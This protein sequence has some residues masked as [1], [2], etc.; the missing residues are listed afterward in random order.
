MNPDTPSSTPPAWRT[1]PGYISEGYVNFESIHILL[2][3]F[4]RDHTSPS[5]LP[6]KDLFGPADDF[7]W[8]RHPM[9]E[10]IIRSPANLDVLTANPA[11]PR[12]SI[13]IIEPWEHV[14]VNNL[15]EPVRASKN[16]AY[17]AQK[18]ADAD[19]LL[20][21]I[22][23][24]GVPDLDRLIPLIT[25][26]LAVVVE[27]GD[28]SVQ[29]AASFSRPECPRDD[30]FALVEQLLLSRSPTSCPSIF[31]CLGH[32][33]AAECLV[34]LLRRAV[35]EV[36]SAP[37]LARDANSRARMALQTACAQIDRMGNRLT[38]RKTDG[39]VVVDH[40]RHAEFCVTKNEVREV[41]VKRLSPYVPPA[42]DATHTT[43]PS[44]VPFELTHAHDVLADELEG[45]IDTML[46]YE[47]DVSIAMFHGDEVNQEAILFANW[48]YRLLHNTLI[49]H[50]SVIAAS[51]LSWLLQLP[52]GV[53]ILCSTAIDGQIVTECSAMCISYKD[54][55]TKRV[56][57][58]FTVQFHPELLADLRDFGS[59]PAP[60]YATLKSDD[61]IRLLVRLLYAGMQE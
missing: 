35:D 31:I 16:I 56:R 1:T 49:P 29:D 27:G 22:W 54:F 18:I 11:L 42:S 19:S 17:I 32:Q 24:S 50:R 61:G 48:A 60:S 55:E 26:G 2:G 40:W 30:V 58:S 41:G 12:H 37:Q 46:A 51:P 57:R 14:G 28:P 59:R 44:H 8:D 38:V 39:R 6:E 34:R 13:A 43:S 4:L 23:S 53:E 47:R 52:N 10:K 7:A 15:Q 21:P 9:L 33:L 20:L 5:P 25:A 45:V 3:D 36:L